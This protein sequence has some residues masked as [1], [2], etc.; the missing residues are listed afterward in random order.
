MAMQTEIRERERQEN[1]TAIAQARSQ[2]R[3]VTFIAHD[4]CEVTVTP[5]GRVFHNMADWY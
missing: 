2:N 5:D 1:D 4:G 3:P